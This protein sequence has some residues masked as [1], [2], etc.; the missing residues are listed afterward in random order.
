VQEMFL[1][2]HAGN[3]TAEM[4]VREQRREKSL[5]DQYKEYYGYVFYIGKKI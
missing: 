1:Q 3:P 2:Q 4:L 5:Y